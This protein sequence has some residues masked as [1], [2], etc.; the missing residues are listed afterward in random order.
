VKSRDALKH[1]KMELC[2]VFAESDFL[3]GIRSK[4]IDPSYFNRAKCEHM[5]SILL[6]CL[7]Q[8]ID[9]DEREARKERA[10]ERIDI[11]VEDPLEDNY[12]GVESRVVVLDKSCVPLLID[13]AVR[14]S[15]ALLCA[16]DGTLNI[17]RAW[18]VIGFACSNGNLVEADARVNEFIPDT[19]SVISGQFRDINGYSVTTEAKLARVHSI[20]TAIVWS[21]HIMADI[22]TDSPDA[23]AVW[24]NAVGNRPETFLDPVICQIPAV[25]LVMAAYKKKRWSHVALLA[26][27]FFPGTPFL[28]VFQA[29]MILYNRTMSGELFPS[30]FDRA[31]AEVD[32][33]SKIKTLDE[34]LNE[35][36]IAV[37]S[38]FPY[39]LDESIVSTPYE[40]GANSTA[41][42]MVDGGSLLFSYMATGMFMWAVDLVRHEP[43]M[44]ML[45]SARKLNVFQACLRYCSV[46]FDTE[47]GIPLPIDEVLCSMY[48]VID[49]AWF[50]PKNAELSMPTPSQIRTAAIQ[51]AFLYSFARYAIHQCPEM[52]VVINQSLVSIPR[53]NCNALAYYTLHAAS[54]FTHMDV[55]VASGAF[56]DTVSIRSIEENSRI[57]DV[58]ERFS[59]R[60]GENSTEVNKRPSFTDD[61][62]FFEEVDSFR[63]MS[64]SS[65]TYDEHSRPA[66][67]LDD[68][69]ANRLH[70]SNKIKDAVVSDLQ[71]ALCTATQLSAVD[72]ALTISY[73]TRMQRV[74]HHNA[75]S[76]TRAARASDKKELG[77]IV[78]DEKEF[79]DE[80]QD[81]GGGGDD[82]GYSIGF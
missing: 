29:A 56:R 54:N 40:I 42:A 37:S 17:K 51:A 33:D 68:D 55:S 10:F 62:L 74:A 18:I 7:K 72:T 1:D 25:N 9:K 57:A 65:G 35:K 78:D 60:S 49:K 8:N 14:F 47:T 4:A 12:F 2:A 26:S 23:T 32:K 13:A 52:I 24:L 70:I 77:E 39:M 11:G 19:R 71:L 67:P 30:V 61:I 50:I 34:T 3:A 20:L 5:A 44:L 41:T 66:I 80:D 15:H 38:L 43:R 27:I 16:E 63:S 69:N 79:A 59:A 76:D 73:G 31:Q 82:P 45:L 46:G 75:G 21:V 6:A 53:A 64:S 36:I 81:T 58:M 22:D 28:R 48:S